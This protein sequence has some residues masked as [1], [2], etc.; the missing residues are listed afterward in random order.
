MLLGGAVVHCYRWFCTEAERFAD[1]VARGQTVSIEGVRMRKEGQQS[2]VSLLRVTL[3][4]FPLVLRKSIFV[5]YWNLSL[6]HAV[7]ALKRRTSATLALPDSDERHG[8]KN[9]RDGGN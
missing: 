3:P 9:C 7:G 5:F 2:D 8:P 1:L 4:A 6:D